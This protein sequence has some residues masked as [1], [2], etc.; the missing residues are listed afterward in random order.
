[1]SQSIVVGVGA[2]FGSLARYLFSNWVKRNVQSNFPWGTYFIN[3]AGSLAL[4]FIIG[5]HLSEFWTLLLGTGFIGG[6]TTFS[7][8]KSESIDLL[9]RKKHLLFLIYLG[10]SYCIGLLMAFA[11]IYIGKHF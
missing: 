4:G 8:F 7:T 9:L 3:M 11:G 5:R 1:M 10:L 2:V 6:F